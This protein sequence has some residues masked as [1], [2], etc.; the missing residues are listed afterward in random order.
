MPQVLGGKLS[1]GQRFKESRLCSQLIS[2]R[3]PWY[4][5]LWLLLQVCMSLWL[6]LQIRLSLATP[7]QS[8]QAQP[9]VAISP[10]P[11]VSH[12]LLVNRLHLQF[13][14]ARLLNPPP[15]LGALLM[16]RSPWPA[17]LIPAGKPCEFIK[18]I[19]DLLI[20]LGVAGDV[21]TAGRSAGNRLTRLF[22]KI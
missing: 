21:G 11:L 16:R 8:P 19:N 2:R 18:F 20:N 14:T 6:P 13:S 4:V 7:T 15:A 1:D 5:S 3:L 22:G 17:G 9:L 12:S 10:H